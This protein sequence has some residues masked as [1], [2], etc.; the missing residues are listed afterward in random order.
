[1]LFLFAEREQTIVPNAQ[2]H[3]RRSHGKAAAVAA[4]AKCICKMPYEAAAGPLGP[5]QRIRRPEQ[6][7]GDG[8]AS[9][10]AKEQ[11]S[12]TSGVDQTCWQAS[13]RARISAPPRRRSRATGVALTIDRE[14]SRLGLQPPV[15]PS[16]ARRGRRRCRAAQLVR[17][18]AISALAASN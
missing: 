2:Q 15:S 13:G 17:A 14:S 11:V 9:E 6:T 16:S 4:A 8:R 18:H 10:R 1:M 12:L 3:A 7:G 5:K